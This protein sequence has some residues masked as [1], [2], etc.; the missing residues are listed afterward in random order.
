MLADERQ[1]LITAEVNQRGTVSTADLIEK[2]EVSPITIRRDLNDLAERGLIAKVHGGAR[3][4]HSAN[5]PTFDT[6]FNTN[7]TAK[8]AIAQAASDFIHDGESIAFSAGTTCAAIAAQAV[9]RRNLTVITNSTRV[10]DEFRNTEDIELFVTGGKRTPTE[11]LTGPLALASLQ[12]LHFDTLF[13]SV[14]AADPRTG[15]TTPSV[16]EAETLREMINSASRVIVAFDHSKWGV[17]ALSSFAQWDQ[18][19]VVIVDS[20]M[21]QEAVRQLKELVEQVVVAS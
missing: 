10:A 9:A 11:A 19:D 5:N 15:L 2:F 17:T 20:E 6:K 7:R 14:H 16:E 3:S 4:V 1:N 12:R 21:P 13:T 18:V 8:E